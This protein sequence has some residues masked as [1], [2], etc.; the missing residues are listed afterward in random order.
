VFPLS[1]GNTSGSLGE[2]EKARGNTGMSRARVP[3]AFLV[4]P[5]FHLCF[6]LTITLFVID[7]YEVTVDA[8]T[9]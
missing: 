9:A 2:L 6:Y 1:Y 4:L 3:I 8:N 7:F 5:N